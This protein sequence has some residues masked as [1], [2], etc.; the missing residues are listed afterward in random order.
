MLLIVDVG[1]LPGVSDFGDTENRVTEADTSRLFVGG[2]SCMRLWST[3][4]EHE[5]K[6]CDSRRSA[7]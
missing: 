4:T 6:R 1:L 3:M 2:M 7:M 5:N